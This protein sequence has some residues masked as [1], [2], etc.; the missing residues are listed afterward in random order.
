MGSDI[1]EI[2]DDYIRSKDD[3]YRRA[4]EETAPEDANIIYIDP[5]VLE[6]KL[7]EF[8]ADSEILNS[9]PRLAE[10]LDNLS[11]EQKAE[12]GQTLRDH[13]ESQVPGSTD[14]DLSKLAL[15]KA[16]IEVLLTGPLA[17][18]QPKDINGT[19]Y[20][21]VGMPQE[22]VD[23]KSDIVN[24]A[25]GGMDDLTAEDQARIE[26]AA[27][28]NFILFNADEVETI[29]DNMPGSDREWVRFIGFH[30]G[31]HIEQEKDP[32]TLGSFA[33]EA[34]A[35][36]RAAMEATL[37]GDADV[38][39][40]WKD[41]RALNGIDSIHAISPLLDSG[42]PASTLHMN[43][44]ENYQ[45]AMLDIV[46][47]NYDFENH[48]GSATTA[49]EL[50]REN[51]EAFFSTLNAQVEATN[52]QAVAEFNQ[53]PESYE[54]RGLVVAAQ[55]YTDYMN[56]FEDA[57]RRRVLDQDIPERATSLQ[58][59]PQ[60]IENEYYKQLEYENELDLIN[61]GMELNARSISLRV[62]DEFDFESYEG[63]AT[64]QFSLEDENPA[65]YFAHQR[66][67][68]QTLRSEA[69]EA[70]EQ[71][72]SHENMRALIVAHYASD[73]IA[74][75]HNID[76]ERML[77]DNPDMPPPATPMELD[78]LVT[79]EQIRSYLEEQQR[80]QAEAQPH[81]TQEEN[82]DVP[83][84]GE[85]QEIMRP[86]TEIEYQQGPNGSPYTTSVN[87]LQPGQPSVD[88]DAGMSVNGTSMPDVFGQS[89]APAPENI[90]VINPTAPEVATETPAMIPP[91]A[92]SA[93][94]A[95][96]RL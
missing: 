85:T 24:T 60:E 75:D 34:E 3:N 10:F 87:G 9:Q 20:S 46:Q 36:R 41:M 5:S 21:F 55:I 29:I 76:L 2:Y 26:A 94:T 64:S 89:A 31:E 84:V 93:Y 88:F 83:A 65:V 52:A 50:L 73:K 11:N 92:Q 37:D 47:S 25:L 78:P 66:E 30:E 82:P 43:A 28:G 39:L 33:A 62:F 58:L 45:S 27:E 6:E 63:E 22:Y 90:T 19:E 59:I 67:Y 1:K 13:M 14:A 61:R 8:G 53:N 4:V 16:A 57:Y 81:M 70:Y 15:G 51:P 42:D 18:S 96:A 32:T 79:E 80:R 48:E 74:E 86:A 91:Q 7:E 44:A 56:D 40:A 69:V 35:D 38:A 49:R 77:E 54:A 71:N 12:L 68:V 17:T 72:P 95:E 23:T